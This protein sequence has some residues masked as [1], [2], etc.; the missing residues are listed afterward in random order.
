MRYRELFAGVLTLASLSQLVACGGSVNAGGPSGRVDAGIDSGAHTTEGGTRSFDA[1][2]PDAARMDAKRA[3]DAVTPEA[4]PPFAFDALELPQPYPA[5][6]PDA[7][8]DACI[9]FCTPTVTFLF[10]TSNTYGHALTIGYQM[11]GGGGGA[12]SSCGGGGFSV[13]GGGGSSAILSDATLVAV[14]AGGAGGPSG[15]GADGGAALSGANGDVVTGTFNLAHDA[16]LS[17]YVGGGGGGGTSEGEVGAT[18]SGGGGGSGYYGGGGGG[19]SAV[20]CSLDGSVCESSGGGVQGGLGAGGGVNGGSGFGGG[21]GPGFSMSGID[22]SGGGGGG[23]GNEGGLGASQGGGGGG[24]FGA[25]GGNGNGSGGGGGSYGG[26]GVCGEGFEGCGGV[27]E[28]A[29]TWTTATVLPSAAGVAGGG[30]G[31]L[32]ILTYTPPDGVCRL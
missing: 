6:C 18:C 5:G 7:A 17:V 20:P 8:T 2:K 12:G 19:V 9:P 24:G 31:G 26:L 13:G 3:S 14:A 23:D 22:V 30:N 15:M 28:G 32:V 25:G 16:T 21:G 29:V 27:S 4:G 1:T 11:V 10:Q